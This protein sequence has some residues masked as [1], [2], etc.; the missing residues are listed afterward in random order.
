MSSCFDHCKHLVCC[1]RDVSAS[2]QWRSH[3]T[4]N[5]SNSVCIYGR[6]NSCLIL[7]ALPMPGSSLV[8]MNLEHGWSGKNLLECLSNA[9]RTVRHSCWL[10]QSQLIGSALPTLLTYQ[11]KCHVKACLIVFLESSLQEDTKTTLFHW[12]GL[13]R[14]SYLCPWISFIS[15]HP[16]GIAL[17]VTKFLTNAV[18]AHFC[19]LTPDRLN[20]RFCEMTI[21]GLCWSAMS[22]VGAASLK[23]LVI[24]VLE[25]M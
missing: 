25:T 15:P 17:S 23:L 6:Q 2:H 11:P 1:M 14:R 24:T 9:G 22:Y 8:R 16:V 10:P 21:K 13:R 20:Q 12:W 4:F 5:C 3:T 19:D 7:D 18:T